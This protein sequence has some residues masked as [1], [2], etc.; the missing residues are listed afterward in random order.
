MLFGEYIYEKRKAAGFGLR[1]YCREIGYDPSN[2]SKMERGILSPPKDV[3]LWAKWALPL[4]VEPDSG[5]WSDL[6]RMV[7][8]ARGEI[9]RDILGR[10]DIMSRLPDVFLQIMTEG[11]SGGSYSRSEQAEEPEPNEDWKSW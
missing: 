9:P 5:E 2:W 4:G 3:D 8:I 7:D 1:S 10:D 11:L 6:I